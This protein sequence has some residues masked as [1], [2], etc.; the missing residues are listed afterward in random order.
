MSDRTVLRF[1]IEPGQ[2]QLRR[3]ARGSRITIAAG[4]VRVDGPSQWLAETM[5]RNMSSVRPGAPAVLL[6]AGWVALSSDAGADVLIEH[7][8]TRPTPVLTT[9]RGL[10]R[11]WRRRIGATSHFHT[12]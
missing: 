8:V 7:E 5:V 6:Q 10:V 3:L 11:R 9:L 2:T 12:A 1:R 4:S